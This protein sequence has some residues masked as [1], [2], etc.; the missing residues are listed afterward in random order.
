M[1]T[2]PITAWLNVIAPESGPSVAAAIEGL[3]LRPVYPIPAQENERP[4]CAEWSIRSSEQGVDI[5]R[6]MVSV[7]SDPCQPGQLN[8][9]LN[10]I[11]G[12]SPTIRNV[13]E[14]LVSDR[15][16]LDLLLGFALGE[17]SPRAKLYVLCPAGQSID[18]FVELSCGILAA[19]GIDPNWA[20][21]QVDLAHQTP[22]FFAI[23]LCSNG[24]SNGKL[25]FS[26]SQTTDADNMLRRL[27][28]AP[29]R[30]TL[31]RVHPHVSDN[32]TGRLVV[33]AR[34]TADQTTDITLHTHL[35]SLPTLNPALMTTWERLQHTAANHGLPPLQWSYASWLWGP[36]PS[37]SLYYT[38]APPHP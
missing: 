14:Q 29:L 12:T 8:A 3:P 21:Q 20:K 9:T 37:E 25:Y 19:A 4:Y 16:D 5:A 36:R 30:K 15:T 1:T 38:F 33:T 27:D 17:T 28:A 22:A 23:D 18:D 26:F 34:A 31:E 32:P 6:V 24:T 7:N 11:G 2:D 13:A 35:S 10:T